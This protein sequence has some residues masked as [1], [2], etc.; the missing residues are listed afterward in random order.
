MHLYNATL[1]LPTTLTS[2]ILGNFTGVKQQEI[3]VVR[4]Q[5]HL[6]LL[7]P[8]TET[9]KLTTLWSQHA[10]G[11]VRQIQPFRLTGASKGTTNRPCFFL[12]LLLSVKL[13]SM[14]D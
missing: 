12:S 10:F 3:L 7:K 4:A 6:E 9:G 8:D 5:T 13:G 11:V 1:N 2:A 14:E